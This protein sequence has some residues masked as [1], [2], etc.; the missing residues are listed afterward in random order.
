ML[1]RRPSGTDDRELDPNTKKQSMLKIVLE[2]CLS[3]LRMEIADTDRTEF[4]DM[5]NERKVV[6]NKVTEAMAA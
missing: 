4:R 5:L 2:G 1:S 3:N 6:L